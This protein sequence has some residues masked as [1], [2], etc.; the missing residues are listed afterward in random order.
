MLTPPYADRAD[1][2]PVFEATDH[3]G[4]TLTVETILG[5]RGRYP[6]GL[7]FSTSRDGVYLTREDVLRLARE[8]GQ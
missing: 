4:D 6:D 2:S 1:G 3:E 8:I 7:Y 5:E